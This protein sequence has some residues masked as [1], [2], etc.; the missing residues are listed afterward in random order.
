MAGINGP[1][2][3]AFKL[4]LKLNRVEFI[5]RMIIDDLFLAYMTENDV[6]TDEMME[7]IKVTDEKYDKACKLLL[8]LERREAQAA[9][10]TLLKALILT[11]Q[12]DLAILVNKNLAEEMIKELL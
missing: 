8:L 4:A 5:R 9:R 12:K 3:K 1:I 7:D 10:N 6:L 11:D 2:H